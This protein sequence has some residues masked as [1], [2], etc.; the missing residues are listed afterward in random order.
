[1]LY[2]WPHNQPNRLAPTITWWIGNLPLPGSSNIGSSTGMGGLQ[3][4][5]GPGC[6]NTGAAKLNTSA[7]RLL[8]RGIGLSA[9]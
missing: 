8:W 3:I 9:G 7:A 4:M 6:C 5:Q 2:G 1:M